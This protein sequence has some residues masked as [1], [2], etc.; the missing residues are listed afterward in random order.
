[1]SFSETDSKNGPINEDYSIDGDFE[2]DH[3]GHT[4]PTIEVGSFKTFGQYDSINLCAK[5]LRWLADEV[6]RWARAQ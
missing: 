4:L 6:D 2:C 3:C 5:C 1:M